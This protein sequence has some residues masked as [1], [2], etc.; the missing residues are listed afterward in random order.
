M[1]IIKT[2]KDLDAWK[3]SIEL[4]SFI[5]ETTKKFPKEEVFGITSQIRR[6]A[7][8]V[9]SNIAEGFGRNTAGELKQFIGIA[10]GS[11]S[12]LETLL[13]IA[14]NLGFIDTERFNIATNS[15]SQIF[16]LTGG[17]KAKL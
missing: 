5:Y 11:L 14:R 7:I 15:I 1:S 17:L 9:P 4:V 3:K 2:H 13:I 12:E 8:S 10:Q 16:K 6:A